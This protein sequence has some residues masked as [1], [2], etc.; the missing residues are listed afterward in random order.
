MVNESLFHTVFIRNLYPDD[1]W[2]LRCTKKKI[3]LN[4]RKTP[5]THFFWF[6]LEI[7]ENMKNYKGE[8]PKHHS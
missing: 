5:L 8:T 1:F 3:F 6:I 4:R 7:V 2:L